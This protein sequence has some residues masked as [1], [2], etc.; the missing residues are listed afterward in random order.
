MMKEV[1]FPFQT[2]L[3]VCVVPFYYLMK[4]VR[5]VCVLF[6]AGV[7]GKPPCEF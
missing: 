1:L 6:G 5:R 2:L 4:D 3:C 7:S